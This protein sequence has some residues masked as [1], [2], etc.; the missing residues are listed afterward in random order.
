[1]NKI[2][3]DP[4]IENP[5]MPERAAYAELS[6][7]RRLIGKLYNAAYWRPDRPVEG[8]AQLWESLRNAIGQ[9]PGQSPEPIPYVYDGIQIEMPTGKIRRLASTVCKR[10]FSTEQTHAF[11]ALYQEALEERINKA[12]QD[13]ITEKLG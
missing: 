10:E 6:V 12:I 11:L 9:L 13:F 7:L 1:M 2:K 4:N 5:G 8:E 3:I